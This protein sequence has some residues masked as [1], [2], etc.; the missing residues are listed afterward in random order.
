MIIKAKTQ[1]NSIGVLAMQNKTCMEC[2]S[3]ELANRGFEIFCKKC[4][5]VMEEK[6]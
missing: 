6:K 1:A 2:G 4:G 5:T 3:L